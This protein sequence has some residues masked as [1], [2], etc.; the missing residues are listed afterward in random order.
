MLRRAL[1]SLTMASLAACA[2]TTPDAAGSAAGSDPGPGAGAG[3]RKGIV[4]QVGE[5]D[6]LGPPIDSDCREQTRGTADP[7]RRYVEIQYFVGRHG[8]VRIVPIDDT[9][10]V[11]AGDAVYFRSFGCFDARVVG[12]GR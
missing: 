9:L 8:H 5:R 6:S 10:R 2:S 11:A 7:A 3:W 4:V 12:E 1:A